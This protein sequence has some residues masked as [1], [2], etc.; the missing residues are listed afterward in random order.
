MPW[1]R[2]NCGRRTDR[3]CGICLE[4][5][6]ER[7]ER[8]RRIDAGLESYVPPQDRPGHRFYDRKRV[9]RTDNQRKAL[10]AARAVKSLKQ[11]PKAGGL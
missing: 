8:N 7:D 6:N 2:W 9:K 10:T 4:C 1:C 3:R 5:C 11:M